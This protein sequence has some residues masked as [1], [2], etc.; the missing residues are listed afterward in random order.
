MLASASF[1]KVYVITQVKNRLSAIENNEQ[2]RNS[3]FNTGPRKMADRGSI[4]CQSL[5]FIRTWG[6]R[7][8]AYS[9]STT[10]LKKK[11]LQFEDNL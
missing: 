7:D 3:I 6:R 11:I 5:T 8:F 2:Y 1:I 10:Y 9:E 4:L